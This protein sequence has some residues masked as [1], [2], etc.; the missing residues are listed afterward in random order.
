MMK[1]SAIKKSNIS[2]RTSD[3]RAAFDDGR[4]PGDGALDD[5]DWIRIM[6]ESRV[7]PRCESR[8]HRSKG[9]RQ[10]KTRDHETRCVVVIFV[11]TA[12]GDDD[13]DDDDDDHEDDDHEGHACRDASGLEW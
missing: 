3:A 1:T 7:D 9:G 2:S 5:V 6:V 11:G 10:R 12:K 8:H 13:D 4:P